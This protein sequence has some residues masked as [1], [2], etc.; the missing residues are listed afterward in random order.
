MDTT[1]EVQL[2]ARSAADYADFLMP[3][4]RADAHVLD[5]GCGA[6]T[7]TLGLARTAGRVVGVDA[8][9]AEFTDARS[10]ALDHDISN[11]EFRMGSVYRLEFPS[12]HFDACLCHSVLEALERPHDALVELRRT[13]KPGGV[14][15]AASVEYGGLIVAG[16][17]APLL[18]RFYAIR[19]RLWE[20]EGEGD[21][22]RGRKLRGLLGHAGFERV[23]ATSTYVCYGTAETVASFGH[24]RAADCR[25]P[26]YASSAQKHGLASRADL[27]AM[28]DGWIAWAESPDAYAA[29]AWCRAL[30]WKSAP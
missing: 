3:H 24:G 29:F 9:D 21:P 6:G 12:D 7:I 1:F 28:Y 17:H 13:L 23:V 10:Y 15:A 2:A 18:R 30:G 5:A 22:Y 19:E 11:V 8:N 4:L 16:P 14:L 20:L 26:W 27:D 25:D